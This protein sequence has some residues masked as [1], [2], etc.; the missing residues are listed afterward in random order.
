MERL[1]GGIGVGGAAHGALDDAGIGGAGAGEGAMDADGTQVIEGH[2]A[3]AVAG[4]GSGPAGNPDG[5]ERMHL[6]AANCHAIGWS[7]F[8]KDGVVEGE[9]GAGLRQF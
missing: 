2:A 7:G 5:A 6:G 4:I 8:A 9:G 3:E 1:P